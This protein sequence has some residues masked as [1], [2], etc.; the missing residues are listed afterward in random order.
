MRVAD[1]ALLLPCVASSRLRRDPPR[2]LVALCVCIC[3]RACVCERS[4]L[5]TIG[6]SI[7]SSQARQLCRPLFTIDSRTEGII[8]DRVTLA[9]EAIKIYISSLSCLKVHQT[10]A[11]TTN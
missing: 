11:T 3:V 6:N 2:A 5:C 4:C 10:T 9:V 8:A 7:D 1:S